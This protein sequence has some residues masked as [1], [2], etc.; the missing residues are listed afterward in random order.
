MQAIVYMC[1]STGMHAK[2]NLLI[3]GR[4]SFSDDFA[5]RPSRQLQGCKSEGEHE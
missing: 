3:R 2:T 4:F 1:K 5:E